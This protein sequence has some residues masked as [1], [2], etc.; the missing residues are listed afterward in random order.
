MRL[1]VLLAIGTIF[2]VPGC[3]LAAP[4]RRKWRAQAF[5]AVST[6]PVLSPSLASD[7]LPLVLRDYT[8]IGSAW[9][10]KSV[11]TGWENCRTFLG[12]ARVEVGG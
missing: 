3:G 12:R 5:A 9:R 6:G 11:V 7:E 1:V 8:K 4:S 2:P 10:Q